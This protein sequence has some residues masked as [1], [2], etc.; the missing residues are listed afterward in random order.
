MLNIIKSWPI[1]IPFDLKLFGPLTLF[2][3][4]LAEEYADSLSD[5]VSMGNVIGILEQHLLNLEAV[6]NDEGHSSTDALFPQQQLNIPISI[7]SATNVAATAAIA[8]TAATAKCSTEP[9][10]VIEAV[11][12]YCIL[13]LRLSFLYLPREHTESRVYDETTICEENNM[14]VVFPGAS[15]ISLSCDG[16][17]CCFEAKGVC[18]L[19]SKGITVEGE[20]FSI[21]LIQ[22]Q[23]AAGTFEGKY[24]HTAVAKFRHTVTPPINFSKRPQLSFWLLNLFLQHHTSVVC[25][26]LTEPAAL[27]AL[28]GV[29]NHD[30]HGLK[31]QVI[32]LVP[33]LVHFSNSVEGDFAQHQ[34]QPLI[35][36]VSDLLVKQNQ[37]EDDVRWKSPLLQSLVE[38]CVAI[39]PVNSTASTLPWLQDLFRARRLLQVL[40]MGVYE[41]CRAN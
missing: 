20:S 41:D 13:Q 15:E 31:I 39:E 32:G 29:L 12:D 23:V 37:A 27:E 19:G 28:I 22:P 6:A 5:N 14:R 2:M 10:H 35:N 3:D 8:A 7:R 18:P 38:S 33:H 16:P 9:S 11:V 34:L 1:H 4:F 26:M 36:A 24:K 40:A 30:T 17:N 25:R 21:Q